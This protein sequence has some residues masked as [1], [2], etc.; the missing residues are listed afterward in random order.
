MSEPSTSR[1]PGPTIALTMILGGQDFA[2]GKFG[3]QMLRACLQSVCPGV[4]QVILIDTGTNGAAEE[5]GREFDCEVYPF[6]WVKDFSAARNVALSKIKTDF[7]LW[8]DHDDTVE[9]AE[10]LHDICAN[11]PDDVGGVWCHYF[12]GFDEHGNCTTLHARERILRTDVGWT[13]KDRIHETLVP[14]KSVR[15]IRSD[16]FRV[17]HSGSHDDKAE[18]NLAILQEQ[19]LEEPENVRIWMHMG[20]QMFA[21]RQY[22]D[23]AAWYKRFY[24]DSRATTLDKWQCMTYAARALREV[25]DH[26]AA[27]QA[28]TLALFEFPEWAD[29]WL[30]LADSYS[31]MGMW[32][33]AIVFAETSLAREIPDTLTFV[34]MLDYHFRPYD[35][36]NV[37]YGM[38]GQYEKAIAAC[39]EALKTRP[40][41][42]EIVENMATWQD[43]QRVKRVVD[44]VL[45]VAPSMS[46][47]AFQD[48]LMLLPDGVLQEGPIRD[49]MVPAILKSTERGTQP[50]A[51]FFCGES[52]E[53]WSPV[54]AAETGIGG[55]ET[56]VIE[57]A[58]RLAQDGWQTVVYGRPGRSEGPHGDVFY[59]QWDRFRP[60]AM[61][62]D[63]FVAWR[64][65]RLGLEEL[66]KA[67]RRWLWAHDLNYQDTLDARSA[68][69]FDKVFGV[70]AFHA[71]YLQTAYPF[72][73]DVGVLPNGI[74]LARFEG[75]PERKR[76]RCIYSSSPDRGLM[77]LLIMW[78]RIRQTEPAAELHIFYGWESFDR[79][80]AGNRSLLQ[81]K[82]LILKHLDQPGVFWRGR[83]PQDELAQEMLQ[84]DLWTYPTSFIETGCITG[85]EAM[86]AGLIPVTS[87]LGAITDVVGDTGLL[88][89]GNAESASYQRTWMGVVFAALL[90]VGTRATYKG[91]GPER[92]KQFSWDTS[93]KAWQEAL[94]AREKVA[95]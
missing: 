36:L 30:G 65:P 47:D 31:K 24:T 35:I 56:A 10:L 76:Y 50:K 19:V 53:E 46:S 93:Y 90:D 52:V 71:R 73:Q 61:K 88:V 51:V 9:G 8:L 58:R 89:P 27:L 29:S 33:R 17:Y 86:A 68:A 7:F 92:A 12:Y 32:S 64:N 41:Q 43:K 83:L 2:E 20:N 15:W 13:W 72:L 44:G 55:S 66:P 3:P 67:E 4:D 18:R 40:G 16:E 59:A 6:E 84:G 34:N 60:D 77:N 5:L 63:L 25:G 91:K 11:M 22:G 37:C 95:A 45:E 74:D 28:D 14:S 39:E 49:I 26:Q 82:G 48:M 1:V 80:I 94:G 87:R 57:V 78:P 70:S 69:G 23:A 38:T 21:M 54:T 42:E 81:L 75:S 79:S 85:M 62:P